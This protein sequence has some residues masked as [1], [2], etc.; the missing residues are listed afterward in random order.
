[1]GSAR[2]FRKVNF[3]KN[4]QMTKIMKNLHNIYKGAIATYGCTFGFTYLILG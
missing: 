3:E 1:M 4:Q 2:I